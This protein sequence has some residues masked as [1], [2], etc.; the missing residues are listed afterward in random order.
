MSPL[1]KLLTQGEPRI[2]VFCLALVDPLDTDYTSSLY[3]IKRSESPG[4]PCGDE[5]QTAVNAILYCKLV[6][7]ELKDEIAEI[8]RGKGSL[9]EDIVTFFDASRDIDF[10]GCCIN[11]FQASQRLFRTKIV[12][13][14]LGKPP[15]VDGVAADALTT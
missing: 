11:I 13:V 15:L 6:P 8:L 9:Y 10:I 2:E 12:L 1:T 5:A 3:S 7:D 14:K 4:C